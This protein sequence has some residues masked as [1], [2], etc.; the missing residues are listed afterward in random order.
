MERQPISIYTHSRTLTHTHTHTM[1]WEV[2]A[3][4]A[5]HVCR[6][7]RTVLELFS[8]GK[9]PTEKTAAAVGWEVFSQCYFVVSK[10]GLD[11]AITVS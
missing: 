2:G 1:G 4:V 3:T 10:Y 9:Q 7:S 5:H 11:D 6:L 8:S